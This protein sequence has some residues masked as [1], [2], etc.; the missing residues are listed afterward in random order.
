DLAVGAI[1]GFHALI[2][3][4]TTTKLI[5]REIETRMVGYGAMIAE[6]MVAIMAMIAACVLQPGTY[7]AINSPAGI[8]GAAPETAAATISSWGFP[9]T[10]VEMQSLAHVVG[11]Q[12]LFNG[13]GG[14]PAL[15][16]GMAQ[17]FSNSLGRQAGL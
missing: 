16:V 4:G 15:A 5:S 9:V 2:S 12:T 10:A 7:F 1:S 3:S 11:E 14:A 17:L 6:S 8:V 13:T